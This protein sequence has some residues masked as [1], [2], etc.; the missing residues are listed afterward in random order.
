MRRSIGVIL[1][2]LT[3]TACASFSPAPDPVMESIPTSE[4]LPVATI[5]PKSADL[6]FVE[7]FAIT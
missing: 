1:F 5:A 3:V 6:I 4:P 2:A 7:F